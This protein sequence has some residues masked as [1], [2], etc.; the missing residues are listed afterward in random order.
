MGGVRKDEVLLDKQEDAELKTLTLSFTRKESELT[1]HTT[2][3][4]HVVI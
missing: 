2:D 4:I 3:L 1:I